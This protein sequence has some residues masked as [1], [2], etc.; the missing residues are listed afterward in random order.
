MYAGSEIGW[1][2]HTDKCNWGG[3]NGELKNFFNLCCEIIFNLR[4]SCTKFPCALYLA[5]P[6]VISWQHHGL[7]IRPEMGRGRH[8]SHAD[9]VPH[10]LG[11]SPGSLWALSRFSSTLRQFL[12]LC[13]SSDLDNVYK[14]W[15][16]PL[17]NVSQFTRS[18]VF[19]GIVWGYA[20]WAGTPQKCCVLLSVLSR[21]H[22]V[23]T[24]SYYWRHQPWS[25]G[26]GG[27]C[28]VAPLEVTFPL[29][30]YRWI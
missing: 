13:T 2:G 12:G 30:R 19:S 21:G 26:G 24:L 16:V 29:G 14:H 9:P 5:P 15:S 27:V 18:D 23:P 17:Y 20:F 4:K 10:L 6:G 8:S 1:I 11:S 22:M 25:F 28:R 7:A 3:S